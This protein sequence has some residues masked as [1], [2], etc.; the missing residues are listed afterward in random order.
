[1]GP[2][3]TWR[4]RG[5]GAGPWCA[6]GRAAAGSVWYAPGTTAAEGSLVAENVG[7]P[8]PGRLPGRVEGG[9]KVEH[10]GR[11]RHRHHIPRPQLGGQVVDGVDLGVEEAQAE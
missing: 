10:Q 9:E 8:H 1:W 5:C 3:A 4:F 7:G 11:H 6:T 2:S